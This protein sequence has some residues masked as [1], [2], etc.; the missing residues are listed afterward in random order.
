[1]SF[2]GMSRRLAGLM[3]LLFPISI[4]VVDYVS[5]SAFLMLLALGLIYLAKGLK[6]GRLIRDRRE[7]WFFVSLALLLITALG[8]SLVTATELARGDR[9]LILAAGVPVYLAMREL[10]PDP[11]WIWAGLIGG[12][13]LSMGVALYQ[14]Y[15][16][17][18]LPRATGAVHPILFGNL[19]LS[20][21]VM[22]VAAL[23]GLG[24]RHKLF[25]LLVMLA[26]IAGMLASILSKSR[27]GW[28]AIPPL[29]LLFAWGLSSVLSVRRV[30]LSL[31]ALG[32]VLVV[33][34]QT[35]ATGLR[36]RIEQTA[37]NVTRYLESKDVRDG[38][39]GTS[40]GSR[41]EMWKSAWNMFTENPLLGGG[42]GEFR[43]YTRKLIRQG[44]IS[45]AVG[46]YYHAHNEYLSTL[47]KGGLLGFMALMALF[48][49]PG[50][51][52]F[53]IF[54]SNSDETS[55]SIALAGLVLILAFMSFALSEAIF[56][57]SRP[58]LF[59]GFYLA[60]LMA[61]AIHAGPVK[62]HG[63]Q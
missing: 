29:A 17:S 7:T 16:P 34:Y 25:A 30:L 52:F 63:L 35:P 58:V 27:G 57:R 12:A 22:A 62:D 24:R 46:R 9:F 1:M 31:V 59:F 10:R 33:A 53:Q 51:I 61:Q 60:V 43:D 28:V 5:G 2:D 19:S 6:Q 23:A 13:L 49:V 26:A 4:V 11:A 8:T 39:R 48:L 41:F 55:R 21:G 20:M 37:G 38:A 15:G 44:V 18:H 42:W 32:V 36:S 56:E 50:W 54:K 47:A 45:P 14:V 40:I 3:L